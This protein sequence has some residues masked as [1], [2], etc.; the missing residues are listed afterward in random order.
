MLDAQGAL[1]TIMM[2]VLV[3]SR[4]GV[5]EILPA[6]P[7]GLNKRSIHGM[8]AC[9]SAMV[10]ALAWDMATGTADVTIASH[11]DRNMS[12]IVRHGIEKIRRRRGVA[13]MPA[14]DVASCE[15]RLKRG[16]PVRL[17]LAL[18]LHEPRDCIVQVTEV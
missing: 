11:K 12:W 17:H 7:G 2:E 15:L 5:I 1:T 8:P 3:Y 13:K 6:V 18:G 10:D 14:P 16:V 4:P 9:T